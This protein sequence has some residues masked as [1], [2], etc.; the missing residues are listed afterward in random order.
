MNFDIRNAVIHNVQGLDTEELKGVIVDSI[1]QGEEKLLPGL[2]VLFEVI[3]NHS[4][5]EKQQ[6]MLTTLHENINKG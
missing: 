4:T 3:W 1:E 5:E 6:E 2:G